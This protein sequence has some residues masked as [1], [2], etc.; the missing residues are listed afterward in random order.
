ML[1]YQPTEV[2]KSVLCLYNTLTNTKDTGDKEKA[3]WFPQAEEV[4]TNI[5]KVHN[6]IHTNIK[7]SHDNANII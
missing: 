4:N 6:A 7:H 3:T 5:Y 2:V 1:K